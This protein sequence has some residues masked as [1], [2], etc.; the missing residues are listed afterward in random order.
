MARFSP[1]SGAFTACAFLLGCAAALAQT[2]APQSQGGPA[3]ER[4]AATGADAGPASHPPRTDSPQA[5]NRG[6]DGS[7]A[8]LDADPN[9]TGITPQ[10]MIGSATA[11]ARDPGAPIGGMPPANIPPQPDAPPQR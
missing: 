5:V 4:A 6:T 8:G 1:R 11:G 7:A 9:A 2:A 10:G 3:P